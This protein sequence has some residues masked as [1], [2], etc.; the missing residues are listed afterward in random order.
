MPKGKK[1]PQEV[2]NFWPEVFK[3]V[4]VQYVPIE[5][6]NSV[7]IKFNDGKMWII[8]TSKNPSDINIE[9]A[10]EELMHEYEDSI[11][12]VDF[13]LDT[14]RVK[15]DIVERTKTFLKKRK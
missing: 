10:L 14:E 11:V 3:D 7:R 8:D 4:T 15:K 5:Y 6:L 9:K 12:N 13:R 1:L 2:I